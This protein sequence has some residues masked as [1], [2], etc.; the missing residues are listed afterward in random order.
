MLMRFRALA[1]Q[2]S[3]A[4]AFAAGTNGCI[5]TLGGGETGKTGPVDIALCQLVRDGRSYDGRRIR[6][7]AKFGSASEYIELFDEECPLN[8]VFVESTNS[9]VDVT[10]CRSDELSE[11]YGCPVN[12]ESGVKATFTGT[13]H[14]T[15]STVG[16]VTVDVMSD[17]SAER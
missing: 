7:R 10:L 6:V 13:Y 5:S 8:F 14:Y 16:T 17:I 4:F 11:K 12:R 3:C 15:S 2:C 1:W 9:D